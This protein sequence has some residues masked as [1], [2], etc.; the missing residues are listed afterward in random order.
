MI[1]VLDTAEMEGMR[2]PANRRGRG[3]T[4]PNLKTLVFARAGL[5]LT[6]KTVRYPGTT[7]L[8]MKSI[9]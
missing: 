4:G 3:F 7:T 2:F 8:K 6:R 1:Q 5:N 9:S